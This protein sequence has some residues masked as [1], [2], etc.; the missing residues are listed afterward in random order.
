MWAVGRVTQQTGS[1]AG[2]MAAVAV[3]G[4]VAAAAGMMVGREEP[5]A[6]KP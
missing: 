4:I 6:E 1:F 2:P 3:A 5:E